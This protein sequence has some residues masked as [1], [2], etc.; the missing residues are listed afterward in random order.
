[1]L[2]ATLDRLNVGFSTFFFFL[3]YGISGPFHYASER[4]KRNLHFDFVLCGSALIIIQ[5]PFW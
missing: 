3:T 5:F 2:S 1:M 4:I